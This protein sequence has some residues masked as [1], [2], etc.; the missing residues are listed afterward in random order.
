MHNMKKL[1]VAVL[2]FTFGCATATHAQQSEYALYETAS[3][4]T[5]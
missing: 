1:I 4:S 2:I 5:G 3:G